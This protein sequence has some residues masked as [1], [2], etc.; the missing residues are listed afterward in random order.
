MWVMF[1]VELPSRSMIAEPDPRYTSTYPIDL[2]LI[3]PRTVLSRRVFFFLDFQPLENPSFDV[4]RIP[5]LKLRA[6]NEYGEFDRAALHLYGLEMLVEPF[7]ETTISVYD[8]STDT[9]DTVED[10]RVSHGRLA[11]VHRPRRFVGDGS[12]A[13]V[14]RIVEADENGNPRNDTE[15]P[16]A[17]VGESSVT[18]TLPL[19]GGLYVVMVEKRNADGSLAA[20]GKAVA[21][22]K[23]VRREVRELTLTDRKALF[24]AMQEYYTI[25]PEEGRAKYGPLFNNYQLPTAYHNAAVSFDPSCYF[26]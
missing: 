17:F 2:C 19:A 6:T 26:E 9:D 3:F 14:W 1:Q 12:T 25:S 16:N 11:L 20:V 4:S 13:Y 18:V 5:T 21:S 22:C 8:T 24:S 7:R 10:S 15:Q 23:Y